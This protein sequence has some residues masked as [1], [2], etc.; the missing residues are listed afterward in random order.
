M[1][2]PLLYPRLVGLLAERELSQGALARAA[3]V[4]PYTI[5]LIVR[6]RLR[7]SPSLK[8]RIA[9]VLD[10]DVAWL[11]TL[12]PAV[13][14]LMALARERGLG[15]DEVAMLT[16]LDLAVDDAQVSA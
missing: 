5:S 12:S 4:T 2:A 11:F 14:E 7:P 1:A 13:Q 9:A 10:V 16:I 6:G 8:A 3:G 15:D